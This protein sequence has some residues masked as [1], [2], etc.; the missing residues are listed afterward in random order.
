MYSI[1]KAYANGVEYPVFRDRVLALGGAV[2]DML[3]DSEETL[4]RAELSTPSID[5]LQE[6]LP[7]LVL[8]EDWCGDCADNLPILD[9]IARETGK[10]QPRIASRDA[11]PD[12]MDQFLTEG[13]F[14]SIPVII[15]LNPD[16]TPIGALKERPASVTKRR[17]A[18]AAEVYARNP[19]FGKQEDSPALLDD[20]VRDQLF[21]QLM[22]SRASSRAFAIREVVRELDTI[23]SGRISL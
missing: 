1:K 11:W 6:P 2:A 15:I 19:Q 7:V 23:V 22:E 4:A 20:A 12:I 8:S 18:D 9:R 14:R 3:R 21:S 5:N 10:L 17:R 13:K 16:M